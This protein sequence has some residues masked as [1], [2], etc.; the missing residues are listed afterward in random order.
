MLLNDSGGDRKAESSAGFLSGKEWIEQPFLDIGRDA[1]ASIGHLK[2][3]NT[4]RVI[5][6]AAR[7]FTSSQRDNAVCADTVGGVLDQI[8]QHLFDLRRINTNQASGKRFDVD[9]NA[10]FFKVGRKESL[11]FAQ[12]FIGGN[13]FEMGLGWTSEEQHVLDN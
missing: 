4:I 11:D 5:V 12:R 7:V 6:Q 2:D 13:R 10:G 3:D 9:S 1:F 8:N